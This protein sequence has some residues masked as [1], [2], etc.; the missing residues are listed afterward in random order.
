MTRSSSRSLVSAGLGVVLFGAGCSSTQVGNPQGPSGPDS[1]DVPDGPFELPT[2]PELANVSRD[3]ADRAPTVFEVHD[4]ATLEKS[5]AMACPGD[6]IRVAAG[7]YDARLRVAPGVRITG[8][9]A[10][11]TRIIGPAGDPACAASESAIQGLTLEGSGTV[12]LLDGVTNVSISATDLVVR[13]G[14][15]LWMRDSSELLVE[16]VHIIGGLDS[17]AAQSLRAPLDMERVPFAGLLS[18]RGAASLRAVEITGFAAYGAAF[19]ASNITWVG[20]TIAQVLVAGVL[21]EGSRTALSDVTISGGLS[22]T[23]ATLALMQS[24]LAVIGGSTATLSDVTV[25]EVPGVG[26][27]SDTSMLGASGL[28]VSRSGRAGL[29]FQRGVA[30]VE[31]APALGLESVTVEEPTGIAVRCLECLDLSI[32]DATISAIRPVVGVGDD[33]Q[34]EVTSDGLQFVDFGGFISLTRVTVGSAERVSL[35][36]D[37]ANAAGT[38]SATFAEVSL[39]P[40]ANG[41]GLVSQSVSVDATGL[42]RTAEVTARDDA[43]AESGAVLKVDRSVFSLP[44]PPNVDAEG[45][46]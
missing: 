8:E 37:R 40:A 24:G 32:T 16:G 12:L 30:G 19:A 15:G 23:D 27:L 29:W 22:A 2:C 9:G 18:Q 33:L 39:E 14:I 45:S 6:E 7:T 13:A 36:L 17:A 43:F 28:T 20:G 41:L 35:L 34:R 21:S 42:Q 38:G 46:P 25:A 31:G 4:A 1:P 11:S 3:C 5:A 10:A 26:V 44:P